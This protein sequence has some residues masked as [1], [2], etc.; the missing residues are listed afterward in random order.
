[1]SFQRRICTI[2][3][4]GLNHVVVTFSQRHLHRSPIPPRAFGY[5]PFSRSNLATDILQCRAKEAT[6]P[7]YICSFFQQQLDNR[8]MTFGTCCLKRDPVISFSCIRVKAHVQHH[9]NE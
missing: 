3:N 4:Q 6:S 2:L 8:L 1:M 9:S 5:A 7:V